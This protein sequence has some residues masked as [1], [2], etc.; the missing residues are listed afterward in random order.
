MDEIAKPNDVLEKMRIFLIRYGGAVLFTAV[1]LLVR[2]PLNP[3]LGNFVPFATFYGAVA[4]SVWFGGVGPAIVAVILS[5]LVCGY[6]LIEPRGSL[7]LH[8][9]RDFIAL[10]LY[11]SSCTIIIGFGNGMLV[12]RR[13]A[14]LSR[15]KALHKQRQL[16]AEVVQRRLA[17][18][19]I[20]S[21]VDT[22]VDGIIT[23]DE[24]GI[25]DSFNQA[26]EKLFGYEASEVIGRNVKI[27]MPASCHQEHDGEI[28]SF[29]RTGTTKNLGSGREAVGRRKNGSTFPMDWA[30]G[31]FQIDSR[32]CFTGVVRDITERKQWEA[33]LNETDRRKDEFLATLAHELRNPL[34]P[35]R[36]GLQLM[37]IAKDL[38]HLV[39]ESQSIMERQVEQLVRLVDDLLDVSRIK[40]GKLQLRREQVK[41]NAV[42][43]NAVETSR[44]LI[45]AAG[46][47]LIVTLPDSPIYLDGDLIRLSQVFSNLLNNSAKYT[48]R[49]GCIHFEAE[50]EGSDVVIRVRDTGIGM[51][52][53]QL[54]HIFDLFTQVHGSSNQAQG[55]LGIGLALVKRLVEMHGGSILA[56]SDGPNTGS[57]FVV[58]LPI[59][60]VPMLEA[61]K[62]GSEQATVP[63]MTLR[64]LV[65][66]DNRDAA[67]SLAAMLQVSGHELRI[68]Y[69]GEQGVTVATE[70]TPEVIFL[71]IGLPN[72]NG[73]EVARLIREQPFG[74][75]VQ[76]IAL[77]GWGQEEDKRRS[78]EAGIDLHMVKPL[79]PLSLNKLLSDLQSA[80]TLKL[81]R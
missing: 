17:E 27:L 67:D 58:R 24:Q 45:E 77:S 42:I 19:R 15:E 12:A 8:E 55:G 37:R 61:D 73:Y 10:G 44:P 75:H 72:L 68:A 57:E 20:R 40:G 6:F 76:L 70:F 78:K 32:R 7:F 52:P 54:P 60:P 21:V 22:V 71:D 46:H 11:L 62:A 14:E 41:L 25:I 33:S 38:P 74:Q 51:S 13:R 49:G 63:V 43:Q 69:D 34:A 48:E 30:V 5:Y 28:D 26:A 50:R 79:D 39:E 3:W 9:A 53:E 18:E 16:E 31:E 66:D 35:I 4:A 2:L 47:K 59:V 29:L 64:I 1:A 56:R 65:I 36:N 23:F 80:H 81:D